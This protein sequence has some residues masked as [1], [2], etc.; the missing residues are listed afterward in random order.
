MTEPRTGA[1]CWNDVTLN[2]L[3]K[4]D[5][6]EHKD[7]KAC[8]PKALDGETKRLTMAAVCYHK[9]SIGTQERFKERIQSSAGFLCNR[10]IKT[11][12]NGSSFQR[13]VPDST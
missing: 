12:F 7:T 8:S 9:K 2:M 5:K 11:S 4:N 3:Q 10:T 6:H 13:P 1:E